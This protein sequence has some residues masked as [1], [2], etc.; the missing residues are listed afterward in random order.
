MISTQYQNQTNF[1]G[2]LLKTGVNLPER[3]FKK[4]AEIF[5]K[6]TEGLP[7]IV[8]TG[9]RE[10]DNN[11]LF[12]HS[13]DVVIKGEDEASILTHNL[14]SMFKNCSPRKIAKELVNLLRIFNP[15]DKAILLKREINSA[16]RRLLGMK[17]RL[18]VADNP[19]KANVLE[20]IVKRMELSI[21]KK[22]E[23]YNKI[24]PAVSKAWLLYI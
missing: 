8:L 5:A 1:Q 2:N 16:Q 21:A 24:K 15:N 11:G 14:K 12:Y 22:Q 19:E 13:T 4:V 18:E 9:V 6:K 10:H 23:K 17:F 7:D 3:K 20:E